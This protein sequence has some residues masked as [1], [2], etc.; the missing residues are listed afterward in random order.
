MKPTA[1]IAKRPSRP[2]V[3]GGFAGAI[4]VILVWTAEVIGV[5]IPPEVASA[6]TTIVGAGVAHL[7][8]N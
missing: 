5:A 4:T 6:I 7:T 1:E 2:I 8:R 3:M